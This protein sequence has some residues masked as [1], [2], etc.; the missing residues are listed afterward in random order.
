MAEG[1]EKDAYLAANAAKIE[2]EYQIMS[3]LIPI[4]PVDMINE[5]AKDLISDKD[6][7][8]V[9][10][11]YEQEKDGKVYPTEAQMQQTINGVRAE[12]LE[13]TRTT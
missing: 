6:T 10:T 7:N 13:A 9:V 1:A 2:T 11:L 3:Q 5:Y 4:L 12:Q 8:L